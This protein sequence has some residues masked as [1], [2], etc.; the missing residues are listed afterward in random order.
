MGDSDIGMGYK[1]LEEKKITNPNG[2]TFNYAIMGE[3]PD[4]KISPGEVEPYNANSR[5]ITIGTDKMPKS[6]I[7]FSY[8]KKVNPEGEK[9]LEQILNSFKIE[10]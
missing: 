9:Q 6:A 10:N 3:D 1:T 8:D 2:I 5:F 7:I 4:F